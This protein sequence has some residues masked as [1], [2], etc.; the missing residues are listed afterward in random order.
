M[1][2]LLSLA[3]SLFVVS[4]AQAF[5]KQA[6]SLR[7]SPLPNII[8]DYGHGDGQWSLMG[9]AVNFILEDGHGSLGNVS[10][11]ETYGLLTGPQSGICA[12]FPIETAGGPDIVKVA[13]YRAGDFYDMGDDCE[14]IPEDLPHETFAHFKIHLV[15]G[16]QTQIGTDMLQMINYYPT[17]P[18]I[19]SWSRSE[20]DANAGAAAKCLAM[21]PGAKPMNKV[22]L[23]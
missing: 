1:N 18:E 3:L 9:A 21:F 10:T 7:S 6:K 19:Q 20:D 22:P 5:F 11:A 4:P 13:A 16:Q 8:C 2:T 14:V 23:R 12:S 17:D 15:Q